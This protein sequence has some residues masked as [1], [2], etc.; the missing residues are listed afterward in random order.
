MTALAVTSTQV[1]PGTDNNPEFGIA[2]EAI[3][4]GQVVY[5]DS[6][7][8]LYKLF[9]AD[10][11][12]ANAAS[13][14]VALNTAAISQPVRVAGTG[15]ITIGA[16]AAPTRGVVYVAG[17]TAGSI[18]PAADL[19]TGWKVAVIGVGGTTANTIKLI[20]QNTGVLF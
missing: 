11:T 12:A 19:A 10:L 17:A 8:N 3:T 1:L 15:T 4:A 18:N 5:L 7:T 20:C 13:P 16:G 2:G 6:T 9:D 14:R